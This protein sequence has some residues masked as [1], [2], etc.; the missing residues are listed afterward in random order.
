MIDIGANLCHDSFDADRAAVIERARAVGVQALVVT[1]SDRQSSHAALALARDHLGYLWSTA[2]VHPHHAEAIDADTLEELRDI[3]AAAPVC[4]IG[5]TGL[6]YFRNFSP[7]AAQLQGFEAQL[8]LASR[9]AMPVFLHQRDAH[10]DFFAILKAWRGKL[11]AAVVHCFTDNQK[12][13]RDY[14]DLDAHIGLT[15]WFCDERRGAHLRELVNDIPADR[16]MVETDAPYL[17]PRDLKP[18]P[19]GRRNEPCHL[20]HIAAVIAE[21]RG[22][23]T[24]TF[25][26][27]TEENARRFFNMAPPE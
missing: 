19:S 12:A 8:E 25:A 4:A 6:D 1:G 18:K 9:L 23:D 3:A 16:L 17:M 27:R 20:P 26:S 24:Q 22:E 14:L 10:E 7:R 11:P 21:A 2:G 5:E 15:G 13:L